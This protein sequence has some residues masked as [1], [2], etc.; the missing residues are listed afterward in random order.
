MSSFAFYGVLAQAQTAPDPKAQMLQMVGMFVLM[1][2]MFYFALFR[3]QQKKAK[4]H[5]AL[6]KA[7]KPRDE[8]VTSSGI[9]GVIVGVKEKTVTLRTEDTKIEVL[10]SAVAE[11]VKRAD[12]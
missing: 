11:I 12:A 1:G 8:I 4:E 5:A 7:L 2:V 9:V 10:R 6:M 3:P